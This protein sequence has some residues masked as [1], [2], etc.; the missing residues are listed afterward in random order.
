MRGNI[1]GGDFPSKY[2]MAIIQDMQRF[3]KKIVS[4]NKFLVKKIIV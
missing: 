4:L 1:R 2:D 3:F